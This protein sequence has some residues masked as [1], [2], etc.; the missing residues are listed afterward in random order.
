MI[1]VELT[2]SRRPCLPQDEEKRHRQ[3]AQTRDDGGIDDDKRRFTPA[4]QSCHFLTARNVYSAEEALFP[5]G[6][7]GWLR[8]DDEFEREGGGHRQQGAGDIRDAADMTDT[9]LACGA[10]YYGT[11]LGHNKRRRAP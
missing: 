11:A 4:D 10:E 8:I 2:K 7:A 1:K 9:G 5:P 3:E 6:Q